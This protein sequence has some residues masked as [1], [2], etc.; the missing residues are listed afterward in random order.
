[1]SQLQNSGNTS[2]PILAQRPAG[3]DVHP[4]TSVVVTFDRPMDEAETEA[5]FTIEPAVE[6][7][8]EWAETT[9]TFRPTE[10]LAEY[11]SYVV[12]VYIASTVF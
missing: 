6:G 3:S 2:P 7:T 8:F 1:M 5:A 9:L 4:A 12:G 11:T 10:T